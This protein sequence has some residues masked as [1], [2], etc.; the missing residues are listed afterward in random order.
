MSTQTRVTLVG[1]EPGRANLTSFPGLTAEKVKA[2]LN[3]C[4]EELRALGFE[5]QLCPIPPEVDEAEARV[6]ASLTQHPTD[7]VVIGAGVRAVPEHLLLFERL[8]NLVIRRA[9]HARLC[10][11]TQPNDTVQAVQRWVR[12]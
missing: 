11:N 12:R 3:A 5:A 9:P 2:A 4:V 8:L 1:L 7:I 10:F 6:E